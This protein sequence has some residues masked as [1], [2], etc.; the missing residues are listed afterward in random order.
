MF[1]R[2][3]R[4]SSGSDKVL[5]FAQNGLDENI[6]SISRG[7]AESLLVLG[8][9]GRDLNMVACESLGDADFPPVGSGVLLDLARGIS[10]LV[11]NEYDQALSRLD[12]VPDLALSSGR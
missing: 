5:P 3:L 12:L 9:S 4:L 6:V 1:S 10:N 7:S 11:P 8:Y 2:H